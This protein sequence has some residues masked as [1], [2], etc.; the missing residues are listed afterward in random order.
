MMCT[1]LCCPDTAT[2]PRAIHLPPSEPKLFQELTAQTV[3]VMGPTY[4]RLHTEVSLQKWPLGNCA[5]NGGLEPNQ[6]SHSQIQLL[7]S[8]QAHSQPQHTFLRGLRVSR[9]PSTQVKDPHWLLHPPLLAQRPENLS[10]YKSSLLSRQYPP[11]QMICFQ[12]LSSA[13]IIMVI[14]NIF[15]FLKVNPLLLVQRIFYSRS[16][17]KVKKFKKLKNHP[18]NNKNK[19]MRTCFALRWGKNSYQTGGDGQ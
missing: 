13:N 9:N 4:A 1:V 17:Y 11:T 19:K 3:L 15:L 5:N 7:L 18:N 6:R 12:S 16:T 14:G 10:H 2:I 8:S